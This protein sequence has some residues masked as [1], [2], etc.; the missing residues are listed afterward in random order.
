MRARG[1]NEKRETIC[2]S[3]DVKNDYEEEE[4]KGKEEHTEGGKM[5]V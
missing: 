1:K 5:I 2:E 4:K 3:K